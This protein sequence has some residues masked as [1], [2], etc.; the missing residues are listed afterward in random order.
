MRHA[1]DGACLK[2]AKIFDTYPD[3]NGMLRSWFKFLQARY[4]EAHI[5]CAGRGRIDQEAAYARGAS[6]AHYGESAHN[7]NCAIDIFVN[8]PGDI[9]PKDWFLDT[10][11]HEIPTFVQWGYEW[12]SFPEM[13]H[14][15]V[16]NWK[17]LKER[18]EL[19]L[20][21]E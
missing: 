8:R 17:I 14:L 6:R 18:G 13:P 5:S 21:E 20:V 19:Q 15:E 4:P 16:K 10:L 3:F 12:K 7:Y 9:Y 1:N 11:V 2:C